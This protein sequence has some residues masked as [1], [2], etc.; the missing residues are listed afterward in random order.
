MP[1]DRWRRKALAHLEMTRPYTVFHAGMVT[2]AAAELASG[3]R[4]A[5]WR[6]ALA[7]L[8]TMCGWV[9][10]LYAGDYYDREID[11]QSK[12]FR[13]VPSGRVSPR[14]ALLTMSGLI[15]VGYAGALVLGVANLALAV[16]T[17]A[18][19]IAYS[20]TFKDKALLGNFDRGVLGICAVLFGALAGGNPHTWHTLVWTVP[21]LAAVVFF[22]DSSTNLVG[23]IRDAAGD[24]AAGCHTV[25]VVYGTRRAVAIA[26]ALA[27]AW[28]VPAVA[29]LALLRPGPLAVAL[30]AAAV[31]L[32]TLVYGRLWLARARV[33]RPAALAAHKYLVVERVLLMSAY[34][35]VFAAPG[36]ALGL[37]AAVLAATMGAQ[38]LLRDRHEREGG[39]ARP[40]GD[41]RPA[42]AAPDRATEHPGGRE[43]A[44]GGGSTGS[45]EAAL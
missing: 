34:I 9:A 45:R 24:G 12:P 27:L 7:A 15:L 6:V 3:G 19:G 39:A 5:V 38:A 43:L 16:V 17:T 35:A 31:A 33:T 28:L 36:A 20:K 41:A 21:L 44:A 13:P 30:F 37:L 10:G 8:V 42:G 18:L 2:V 29:L 23:A 11:A 40:A 25:P 1:L 22:H 26:C 32:D 14:E 4:A